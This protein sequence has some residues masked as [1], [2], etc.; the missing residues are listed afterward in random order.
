MGQMSEI[1]QE[2]F[3]EFEKHHGAGMVHVFAVGDDQ[4]AFRVPS[5][6]DV[7]LL[8]LARED[9]DG[10]AFEECAM[11]C[12]LTPAAPAA[13]RAT[14]D[15]EAAKQAAANPPK[16]LVAEKLRLS[17][18]YAR[19]QF[20]RDWVG[21]LVARAAGFGWNIDE[22]QPLQGGRYSIACASEHNDVPASEKLG[23]AVTLQV[24][25]LTQ[26]EYA[27]SRQLKIDGGDEALYLFGTLVENTDRA[28]IARRFPCLPAAL[29][30]RLIAL[31]TEGAPV[32]VKKFVS[33]QA[34]A[35]GNSGGP[36]ATGEK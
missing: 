19:A 31:G 29:A 1:T 5:Q 12:L 7:E 32:T 26:R 20:Y 24:R 35:P 33:G 34:T 16:E 22:A 15:T 11:R 2:Q 14:L 21:L 6:N 27:K 13:N 28:D 3:T 9:K 4:F 23:L 25:K 36:Q 30:S 18:H 17:E 10:A 8:M